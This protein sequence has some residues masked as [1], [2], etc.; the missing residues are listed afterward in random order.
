MNAT[1]AA[2][3]PPA[4]D[5][6][7]NESGAV[8]AG[9]LLFFLLFASYF[10]LRPVRETFGIAG[11]VDNIPWLYLGTFVGALIAVPAFGW[12]SARVR[13]ALLLPVT[14][15]FSAAVMALFALSLLRDP[16]D[17]W[18]GRAFYVWVS[19]FN[20]FVIS[21]AWSLMAD[22]FSPGQAR[23]LFGRLAA[24]GSLGALAG[25]LLSGLLVERVDLSGLLLISTALLLATL[26]CVAWLLRWRAR[27]GRPADL[28]SPRQSMGGG[29]L[30]GLS[31]IARSRHLQAICLFVILLTSISTF[32][33]MA[34]ARVVEATFPNRAD[35]T[36]AFAAI[37]VAVQAATIVVQLVLTGLI[38]RRFGLTALLTV[39]PL[40][41]V[42]GF[43][44]LT[45]VAT[46]PVLVAVMFVR[47]VGEYAMIRPGREMLFSAV[48]T[49]TKY[50][51]KNAIDTAVYRGGDVIS[52][53]LESALVAIGSSA[54]AAG[55][56]AVIALVWAATGFKIGR[57][58]DTARDALAPERQPG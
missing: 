54:V 22:V 53:W 12:V 52:A 47:R 10:M 23:R 40:L 50:K 56:G 20:L 57:R 14:Y 17:V 8:F 13:R 55:A 21:I 44:L 33:Y 11:G 27:H 2:D 36:Q 29:I 19:V 51:S 18:I 16:E 39:V 26:P 31:I 35:Q 37:D 28:E 42:G 38:A 7:E 32:L 25:P 30:A 48:D 58:F 15:G 49:E 9:F 45:V 43:A 1:I 46:F 24:G 34:Q 6:S 5:R 3:S 4:A 41:M